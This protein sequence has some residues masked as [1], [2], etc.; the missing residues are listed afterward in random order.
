MKKK[1]ILLIVLLFMIT[2][3]RDRTLDEVYKKML[4]RNDGLTG[5]QINLRI[6]GDYLQKRVNEY[7]QIR[8]YKHEQVIIRQPH[9]LTNSEDYL[10]IEKDKAYD[11]TSRDGKEVRTLKKGFKYTGT[12][13][14]IDIFKNIKELTKEAD[15][16]ISGKTYSVYK[17]IV[18]KKTL[19]PI[20][21]DTILKDEVL[22]NDVPGMI[23]IDSEGYIHK[24][25]YALNEVLKDNPEPL[26]LSINYTDYNEIIPRK[27]RDNLD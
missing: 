22:E 24:M 8:N 15:K 23:W 16:E 19:Y 2:G 25:T 20:L 9:R 10:L 17:V 21:K 14:Y 7:F 27:Y 4:I 12:D 18:N 26:E 13:I 3:C 11:V 6:T 1:L 5:Y